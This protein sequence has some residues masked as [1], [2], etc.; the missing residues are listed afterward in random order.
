MAVGVEL[1]AFKGYIDKCV[2]WKTNVKEFFMVVFGSVMWAFKG[3]ICAWD[4]WKT[5]SKKS[6]KVKIE[7]TRSRAKLKKEV[8]GRSGIERWSK[9]ILN[10]KQTIQKSY[11]SE[12]N[13]QEEIRCHSNI[14]NWSNLSPNARLGMSKTILLKFIRIKKAPDR[15]F[16][17][18]FKKWYEFWNL[19][20]S[21]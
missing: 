6:K 13:S 9:S 8:R 20:L 14:E 12:E 7:Y 3:Y 10:F 17:Y 15:L 19:G 16:I 2:H 18:N 1:W 5:N 11:S 21:C 4:K